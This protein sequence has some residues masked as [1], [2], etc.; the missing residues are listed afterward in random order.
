MRTLVAR[1]AFE[2]INQMGPGRAL[3]E[4]RD[5][6][7]RVYPM[8]M[9]AVVDQSDQVRYWGK[10][11]VCLLQQHRDFERLAGKY[12]NNNNT[13]KLLEGCF[14]SR[15]NFLTRVQNLIKYGQKE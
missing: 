6:T 7:E 12:L 3:S 14:L 4:T 2:T 5:T 1:Y 15:K 10:K 9:A 8:M 11:M 13:A